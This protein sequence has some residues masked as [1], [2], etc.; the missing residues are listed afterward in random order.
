MNTPHPTP[1]TT[2]WTHRVLTVLAVSAATAVATTAPALAETDSL[3]DQCIVAAG[4]TRACLSGTFVTWGSGISWS[5]GGQ[6]ADMN[7]GDGWTSTMEISLDRKWS[8]NTPFMQVL[9]VGNWQTHTSG[10][11]GSD[12]TY[13]A[14][15]RI[16]ST[17]SGPKYCTSPRY[18]N[19][20]S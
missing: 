7:G 2:R 10:I 18:V 9:R 19:D 20:N 1:R 16:C 14:W 5:T 4:A 15:V 17:G 6:L 13:G 12:P 3:R 11:S 8:S